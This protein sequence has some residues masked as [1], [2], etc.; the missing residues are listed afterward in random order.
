MK[1]HND[2]KSEEGINCNLNTDYCGHTGLV[3]FVKHYSNFWSIFCCFIIPFVTYNLLKGDTIF[4]TFILTV[5][6]LEYHIQT[7]M[8]VTAYMA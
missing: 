5:K 6:Y 7:K 4:M 2:T 3:G 1:A 8:L